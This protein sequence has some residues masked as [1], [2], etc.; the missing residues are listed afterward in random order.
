MKI[1]N[2]PVQ[3]AALRLI[4]SVWTLAYQIDENNEMI[5]LSHTRTNP[6]GAVQYKRLPK[7]ITKESEVGRI[8]QEVILYPANFDPIS[9][10][11][12][13]EYKKTYL[14]AN[15]AFIFSYEDKGFSTQDGL[16]PVSLH[17]I[18]EEITEM[19]DNNV[20]FENVQ[21]CLNDYSR[22]QEVKNFIS[23]KG[24]TY[25]FDFDMDSFRDHYE[26]YLVDGKEDPIETAIRLENMYGLDNLIKLQEEYN[27]NE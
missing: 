10:S 24:L 19:L 6:I 8:L 17:N 4:D 9:S 27:D 25:C 12:E 21:Q 1:E 18:P 3:Y 15:P 26:A 5:V 23:A 22:I 11:K 2:T 7:F 20:D 16:I 13:P 14:V